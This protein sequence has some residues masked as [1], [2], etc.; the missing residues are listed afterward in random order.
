MRLAWHLQ[1]AGADV[2]VRRHDV[3]WRDPDGTTTWCNVTEY[4]PGF[5]RF[6]N[7]LAVN[8][9]ARLRKWRQ[10]F[11]TSEP[12]DHAA[13]QFELTVLPDEIDA[14]IFV[15]VIEACRCRGGFVRFNPRF[16]AINPTR[17]WLY[18]WTRLAEA[19]YN[20]QHTRR[21]CLTTP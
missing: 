18:A 17:W 8:V 16:R 5:V 12:R 9:P 19:A 7:H 13:D 15:T 4:Q 3:I 11:G 6:R 21:P 20:R 2:E 1:Q 10:P 14:D